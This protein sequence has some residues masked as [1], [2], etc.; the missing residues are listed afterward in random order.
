MSKPLTGVKV[1]ELST[2][3][4]G[5]VAARLLADLGAEVIKVERPEGDAWRMTGIS[6][7]PG[8]FSEADQAGLEQFVHTLEA[9]L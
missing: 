9:V 2:F 4:A 5:P 8:R 1:L 7:L 3:V 6:Y